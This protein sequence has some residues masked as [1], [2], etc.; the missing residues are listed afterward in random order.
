MRVLMVGPAQEEKGGISTVVSGYYNAGLDKIIDLKYI[1]S[2]KSGNKIY[3]LFVGLRAL[4]D[5]ITCLHRYDIVHIHM[6]SRASFYRKLLFIIIA[7]KGDKKVIIHLHSGLF[8]KFYYEECNNRQRKI[9]N[10]TFDL[11]DLIITLSDENHDFIKE[12]SST[13]TVL[14]EN[15]VLLP[16]FIRNDFSNHNVLFMGRFSQEKG[17]GELIDAF[18]I[19]SSEI[20]D[21]KLFLCGCE[22]S[23][24]YKD[25]I[26]QIKTENNVKIMGWVT[27]IEKDNILKKCSVFVLPSHFEGM[28]M[29][30]LE[31]MSYGEIVVAT[32][33]GAIPSVI[34]NGKNGMLVSVDNVEELSDA[35]KTAL[36]HDNR[37]QISE[38]ARK[39]VSNRYNIANGVERLVD[40]YQS[41]INK[42]I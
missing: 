5:F 23:D 41:I 36:L 2:Y 39:T 13:E 28:P 12:T 11:A 6:A 1:S 15:S 33:V 19:V 34:E 20:K 22:V 18:G 40:I 16:N 10:D 7:K 29:S 3:K 32:N 9:I 8:K 37:K 31:A 38:N 35:I 30:I 17:F 14:L 24:Y 27:G 42:R 4:I 21:A 25:I 26:E